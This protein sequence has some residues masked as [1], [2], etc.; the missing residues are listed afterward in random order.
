MAA[1]VPYEVLKQDG[2]FELRR[3]EGYLT[4]SVHVS[5]S[6]YGQAA[7]AG[8]NP[9]A[10]YIFGNNHASDRI[11]MTAPVSAGRVCCQKIAMTAPVTATQSEGDYLVSFTMP[12]GY[13]MDDLPRP[14]NP[15]VILEEVA[16]H[17]VAAIRFSGYF[18]ERSAA[19][20]QKDLERWMERLGITPVGEPVS[21]Q[22]DAPWKPGFARRNEI[23][24]PVE[25]ASQN[26]G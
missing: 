16:P 20:A 10:D 18:S 2:P 3:Y 15:D 4:A 14:N 9:L 25:D 6:T 26:P 13:S 12:A 21:A 1:T 8:F 7:N 19:R 17:L 22:Y 24:I 5:A 11:A 23:M